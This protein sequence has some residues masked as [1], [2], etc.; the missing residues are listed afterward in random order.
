MEGLAV[1]RKSKN[2]CK[3]KKPLKSILH[4]NKNWS[5]PQNRDKGHQNSM[6]KINSTP[7][8]LFKKKILFDFKSY[9][10]TGKGWSWWKIAA[11]CDKKKTFNFWAKL[12]FSF[13]ISCHTTKKNLDFLDLALTLIVFIMQN[14]LVKRE[15][16]KANWLNSL[17]RGQSFSFDT[18]VALF[19]S[20]FFFT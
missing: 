4:G 3:N 16:N 2:H 20:Q 1:W 15:W 19:W 14:Y 12:F 13:S 8:Y 9:W 17:V 11:F 10:S 5:A 7:I 18:T 6:Q